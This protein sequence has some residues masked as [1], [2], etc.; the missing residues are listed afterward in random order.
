MPECERTKRP[1]SLRIP[2]GL[3]S[4]LHVSRVHA[5]GRGGWVGG[6]C[7]TR[8]A[9]AQHDYGGRFLLLPSPFLSFSE[10]G[11]GGVC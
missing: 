2:S 10:M 8:R 1:D 7:S 6:M 11:A 3:D 9:F 4:V 5:F